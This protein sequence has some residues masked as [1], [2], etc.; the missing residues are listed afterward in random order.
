MGTLCG[1]MGRSLSDQCCL[2][3]CLQFLQWLHI[4]ILGLDCAGKSTALGRLRLSLFVSTVPPKGFNPDEITVKPGG[5]RHFWD[6][7]AQE[8]LFNLSEKIDLR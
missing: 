2:L 8:K 1:D 3:R 4:S 6:V 7:G 5:S